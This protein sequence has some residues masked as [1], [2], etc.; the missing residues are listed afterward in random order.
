MLEV[1][2][3]D[4]VRSGRYLLADVDLT[5]ERGKHW[6]LIGPNG[7]GKSTL[8]KLLGA[9]AHP[10][11]GTVRVLGRELGRV[12]MRELRTHIGYVDPR[13]PLDWPLTVHQVVLTGATQTIAL[14][15]RW[16]A[17]PAQHEQADQLIDVLGMTALRDAK[18]QTLSSGERGRALIARAL[19]PE[20]ALLLL[21]EPATG[22]DLAAREQLLSGLDGLRTQHPD[23]ASVLVTHH[24]E[25]IPASTT[26]RCCCARA[27]SSRRARSRTSSPA[28]TSA[29][30]ST[31]RSASPARTGAGR[32][33]P[34]QDRRMS[35]PDAQ[36]SA[37]RLAEL[38]GAPRHD[39]AVVL[40]SGWRPAADLLGTPA[41]EFDVTEL[42]GFP[43]TQVIGHSSSVRSIDVGGGG[44]CSSS[45]ACTR[46]RVMTWPS[47]RTGYAPPARPG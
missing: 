47:P 32:P 41:A 13:H 36:A 37:A 39:V 7:A 5:V 8:L 26:R 25:E 15:Q 45:A 16:K 14:Q 20:P 23:L 18:W 34:C 46:T 3:V 22:L 12:D 35:A 38:T 44:C 43:A 2:G 42:G 9:H 24:L 28:T 10:S 30:P 17:S 19:M 29:R 11:R 33:V 21:D 27:G 4:F 31:T 40:G 6:V 1:S